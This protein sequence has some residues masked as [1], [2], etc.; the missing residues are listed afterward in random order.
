MLGRPKSGHVKYNDFLS[1][2][3]YFI[4]HFTILEE[5]PLTLND[6]IKLLSSDL[7]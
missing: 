4:S 7:A 5:I 6:F 1:L 2:L 3:P